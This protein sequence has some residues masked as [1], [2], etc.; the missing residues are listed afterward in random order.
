[1]GLVGHDWGAELAWHLTLLRPDRFSAIAALSV[2]YLP[3]PAMSLPEALGRSGPSDLYLLY[4]LEE[5]AAEGELDQDHETFLR[6]IFYANHGSRPGAPPSMRLADNGRLID[7]LDEPPADFSY[8]PFFDLADHLAAFGRTG[9][10]PALDTYRSLHRTWQL[11]AGWADKTVEVPA[12]FI[13]GEKDIVLD[14]PG[15]REGI[16]NM[17]G[18][19]P[20]CHP[21]VLI[22]DTGHFI[23]IERPVECA[24]ILIDFFRAHFTQVGRPDV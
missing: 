23:Q 7:A 8:G 3:R 20:C 6:R 24:Q 11:R 16:A 19:L 17:I 18:V 12:L 14:F 4:F 2:P 9:F 10:G 13:G 15:M 5:G 21:P 22:P 1:V